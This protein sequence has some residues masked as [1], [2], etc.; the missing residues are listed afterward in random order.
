MLSFVRSYFRVCALLICWTFVPPSNTAVLFLC[1]GATGLPMPALPS[2][3]ALTKSSRVI[4]SIAQLPTPLPP[5]V[6]Q[7]HLTF[8]CSVKSIGKCQ[9]CLVSTGQTSLIDGA[10]YAAACKSG[11][12]GNECAVARR[13][14]I[15][16]KPTTLLLFCLLS[17]D[18]FHCTN[19]VQP[20]ASTVSPAF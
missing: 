1:D 9:P 16:Q 17:I 20:I 4:V 6:S 2:V 10:A 13:T 11:S 15:A 18:N 5:S 7:P 12:T 14:L 8:S 3:F 19:V